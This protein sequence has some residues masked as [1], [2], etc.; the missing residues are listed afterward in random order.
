MVELD[1]E[2]LAAIAGDVLRP[3]LVN[4][5]VTAAQEMYEEQPRRAVRMGQSRRNSRPSTENR[6]DLLKRSRWPGTC[7]RWRSA[8][9]ERK[10][11]VRPCSSLPRRLVDRRAQ[12]LPGTRSSVA[13]VRA[14]PI[15]DRCSP[16]TSA[17]F[18]TPS[19]NC[20]PCR[21]CSRRLSLTA[22]AASDL[23]VGSDLRLCF[24]VNGV[25]EMVTGAG[26]EPAAR[27]LKVRCS[28]TELPGLQWSCRCR[29]FTGQLTHRSRVDWSR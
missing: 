20:C 16:A 29:A 15:G 25:I 21:S 18:A 26:I 4:E 9:A 27:A 14:S 28:T 22:G 7:R 11:D 13:C 23:R 19:G 2:V 24:Q 1:R 5:I 10:R 6:R 3:D 12:R 8:C 17:R